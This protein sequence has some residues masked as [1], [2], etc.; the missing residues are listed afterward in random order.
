MNRT[1]A[2]AM[3]ARQMIGAE[4]L[5]LRRHR[6]TMATAFVLSIGIT[7]LYLTAIQI[8]A[9]GDLGGA[10]VLSSGSTLLGAYFGSFAA[11]F[12]GATAGAHD[13]TSGVFRDLVATGRPRKQLFLVRV[14]AAVAVALAFNLCGF[15]LTVAA[16]SAVDGS[17]PA[18]TLGLILQFA[19][20]IVLATTVVTTL[21][22]GASALSGSR[23]LSLTVVLGWQTLASTLLYSVEGLG[24][25]RQALLDVALGHLRPGPA[26]GGSDLPG[27]SNA[28][29]MLVLPTSTAVAV[30]VLVGWMTVPTIAAAWRV[31]SRDA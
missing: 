11:M 21:A 22:V 23:S 13:L 19:G 25:L 15:L 2:R 26:I 20:W 14:P 3:L 1:I 18:P 7:V 6:P 10:Q 31:G 8:R 30:L 16:A 28:L 24:S 5:K 29:P 17:A 27:S 4:I 12:I 9:G